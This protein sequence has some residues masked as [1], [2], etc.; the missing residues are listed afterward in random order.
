MVKKTNL[1]LLAMTIM[2]V[3]AGA[4]LAHA[5][6]TDGLI[7]HW[8]LD[9]TS[10]TTATDS[11]GS[12]DGTL[13]NGPTWVT[14]QI[15]GALNFDGAD[16]YVNIPYTSSFQLPVFSVSAWIN[17]T[18]DL[19]STGGTILARGEDA[20]S[21]NWALV[22]R[23]AQSG[24]ASEGVSI[25]YE[26]N[27]DQ[28]YYWHTNFF[29]PINTWTHI[30]ATRSSDGTLSI[31]INGGLHSQWGATPTPTS[32]C[33]QDFAIGA[34][35]LKKSGEPFVTSFFPGLID[36]VM[37]Y[38]RALSPEEVEQ[39]YQNG[40]PA[41]ESIEIT[42]P[43]EVAE[44]SQA[45]YRAV[46]SYEGGSTADVTAGA[47]WSV[48]DETV[49]QINTPGQLE[50][51]LINRPQK[52]I[53]ITAD[54]SE[55]GI[56]TTDDKEVT[57]T[58]ICPSGNALQFDGQDDFVEIPHSNDCKPPLPITFTA[59]INIENTGTNQWII[60][61]DDRSSRY[62][63]IWFYVADYNKLNLGYG[64][65]GPRDKWHRR[66]KVGT[67]EL[68]P[69]TWYHVAAVVNGPTDIAF[70]INGI[71]DDGIYGGTGGN[72]A[73]SSSGSLFIGSNSNAESYFNGTIDEVCVYNRALDAGE[74]QGLIL[75]GPDVDDLSLVGYW[76]FDEGTGQVA[77][78]L[79][80]GNNG[81]L[82]SD[83]CDVDSSDPVWTDDV[84]PVGYCSLGDIVERNME[85]VLEIKAD[86]LSQLAA[87]ILIELDTYEMLD[88]AFETGQLGT[89]NKNDI[90][91]AKQK[92]HS[93]VQHE[94]Q[95]GADVQ[96]S[97]EK[98]SEAY[99]TLGIE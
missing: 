3:L 14:G 4:G 50:T 24:S 88:E 19:A 63:G 82:G 40:L 81:T 79:A 93:A 35:W 69:D 57:V 97:L 54:Y 44:D 41:L 7:A 8:A 27:G 34:T 51:L 30:V 13:V 87:A 65:G 70:Y 95:A 59:W 78:D 61:T 53:V 55:G 18:I 85:D 42:G 71:D 12:N 92:I 21:D 16:D 1:R 84:A 45:Q 67:T 38:D 62:Y 60:G 75:A 5:D 17:P 9:E 20:A 43:N 11:A 72:L 25:A 99:D 52:D 83:P 36:D 49:G 68:S 2:M 22:L 89:D 46:A 29:P 86:I 32:N 66:S 98:I 80:G 48:D 10:G 90:V 6:L 94:T 58:A 64:D 73:Y 28:D 15:G 47:I 91:K 26:G 56:D 33:F 37:I 77:G 39:L 76:P 96:K 74:I 23:V 31:Y